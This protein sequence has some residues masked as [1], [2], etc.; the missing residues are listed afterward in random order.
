MLLL[1]QIVFIAMM[2]R[3]AR[4][5]VQRRNPAKPDWQPAK[6]PKKMLE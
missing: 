2:N 4:V 3:L 5:A 6:L 1:R